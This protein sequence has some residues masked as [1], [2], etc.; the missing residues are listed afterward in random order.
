MPATANTTQEVIVILA[1]IR[2]L[3]NRI[4][5]QQAAIRNAAEFWMD[6]SAD[7]RVV[8]SGVWPEDPISLACVEAGGEVVV[9]RLHETPLLRADVTMILGKDTSAS[10]AF[11]L[12][13]PSRPDVEACQRPLLVVGGAQV[14]PEIHAQA[15]KDGQETIRF[16]RTRAIG[17]IIMEL[18]DLGK[19]AGAA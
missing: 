7:N 3:N 15:T 5:R 18:S 1:I 16:A 11:S 13:Y 2:T 10:G 12:L 8:T 9:T 17:S 6:S 19:I 4:R 14:P